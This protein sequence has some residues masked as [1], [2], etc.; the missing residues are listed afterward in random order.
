MAFQTR[1]IQTKKSR[2]SIRLTV[3]SG[4][5]FEGIKGAASGK[6]VFSQVIRE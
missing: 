6:L 5:D 4:G 2:P 3:V 1:R